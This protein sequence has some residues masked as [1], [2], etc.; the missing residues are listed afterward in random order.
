MGCLRERD[1]VCGGGGGYTSYNSSTCGCSAPF[2][3]PTNSVFSAHE[4]QKLL[5]RGHARLATPAPGIARRGPYPQEPVGPTKPKP[6]H[7]FISA[8]RRLRRRGRRRRRTG[9]A[10]AKG[11]G[12]DGE[13]FVSSFG[14]NA[15][16][17]RISSAD[18]IGP[19]PE[20]ASKV[21]PGSA[22]RA[23]QPRG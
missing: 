23:Y 9:D 1:G 14:A 15:S 12:G 21:T 11:A 17:A 22:K 3:F 5:T 13:S 7:F 18:G 8:A 20:A 6:R 4:R 19:S 16:F 10:P 2:P